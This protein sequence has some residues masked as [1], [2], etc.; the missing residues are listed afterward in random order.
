MCQASD[1]L[2]TVTALCNRILADHLFQNLKVL[3]LMTVPLGWFPL[4][5]QQ[6]GPQPVTFLQCGCI[7][8]GWGEN[9]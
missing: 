2:D 7:G 8:L 4:G 5:R 6:R 3:L 1:P 9:V